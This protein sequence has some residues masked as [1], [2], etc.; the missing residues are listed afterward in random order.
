MQGTVHSLGWYCHHK[1]CVL[2]CGFSGSFRAAGVPG[3]DPDSPG[4]EEHSALRSLCLCP[5]TGRSGRSRRRSRP[6]AARAAP[7]P[8][9]QPSLCG[10]LDFPAKPLSGAGPARMWKVSAFTAAPAA[11]LAAGPGWP[12]MWDSH[13]CCLLFCPFSFWP[14]ETERRGWV[15]GKRCKPLKQLDFR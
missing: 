11:P 10:A 5:G 4:R 13:T 3:D 15:R 12:V 2:N 1:E 14:T 9:L 7:E 6:A 8:P